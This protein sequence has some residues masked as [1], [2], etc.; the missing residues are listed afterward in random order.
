M[1]TSNSPRFEVYGNDFGWGRPVGVRTG[2]GNKLDGK[3]T[4]YEGRDGGAGQHG[5]RDV[6]ARHRRRSRGSSP[7]RSSWAP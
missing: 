5:A 7:T 6:P 1:G 2:G 4:V 3:M